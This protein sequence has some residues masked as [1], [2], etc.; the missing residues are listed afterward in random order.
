MPFAQTE[1][2]NIAAFDRM[3]SPEEIT[4]AV[5]LSDTAAKVARAVEVDGVPAKDAERY[6]AKMDKIRS[7]YQ[8]F[9][10]NTRF[11]D[12]RRYDLCLN[13]A[14]L[15]YEMCAELIVTAAQERQ[16]RPDGPGAAGSPT[17]PTSA[18]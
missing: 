12:P 1:N 8:Q 7:R 3:P 4:R 13:S 15:G 5:P 16:A 11:G 18:E 6:I 2:L 14:R 10:T 17:E 9:F